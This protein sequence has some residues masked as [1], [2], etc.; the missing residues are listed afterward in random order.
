MGEWPCSLERAVDI[1]EE[2]SQLRVPCWSP[3][4]AFLCSLLQTELL[5]LSRTSFSEAYQG[6]THLK[7]VR[8]FV[9]SVLRFGLPADYFG[10]TIK[11][12]FSRSWSWSF[13][14]VLPLTLLPLPFTISSLAKPQAYQSP[15]H[16]SQQALRIPF[17]FSRKE[18]SN[19]RD[20]CTRWIPVATWRRDIPL[21]A[22]GEL[23][24][25]DLR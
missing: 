19:Y 20:W 23:H 8:T 24:G 21:R 10:I 12:S 6:L 2:K 13:S 7:V 11:V 4:V 25:I 14:L 17:H 1:T 22:H 15:A 3:L 16:D 9:E 5:R 18:K